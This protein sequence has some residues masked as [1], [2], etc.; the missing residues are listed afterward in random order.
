[1][2]YLNYLT[3]ALC[4][5]GL[6]SCGDFDFTPDAPKINTLSGVTVSLEKADMSFY[7]N[8]GIV[9]VPFKVEGERNG[10]IT[11]SCIVMEEPETPETLPAMDGAH[12][13]F[14]TK[15]V[16]VNK[17]DNTGEFEIRLFNDNELN[18]SRLFDIKLADAQGCSI[19]GIDQTVVSIMDDD[20]DPYIRLGGEWLLTFNDGTT[21]G[22]IYIDAGE[23]GT[24]SYN[25]YYVVTGIFKDSDDKDIEII[26]K[27]DYNRTTEEGK[28]MFEYGQNLPQ[29]TSNGTTYDGMFGWSII[30][31][32]YIVGYG[33]S[34]S[35]DFT[36]NES[37]SELQLL[38]WPGESE[39]DTPGCDFTYFMLRGG[40]LYNLY[41]YISGITGLVRAK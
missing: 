18:F 2:K 29:V 28:I 6:T 13:I 20:D 22:G 5:V 14:T 35:A 19:A 4:A 26:A 31:G 7:E 34:G 23:E 27:F 41:D 36:W 32:G 24:P 38:S 15:T 30:E 12:Y 3:A 25:K 40:S 21:Q 11:V 1:M 39:V 10:D 37:A 17:E 16:I 8:K 9:K 33:T